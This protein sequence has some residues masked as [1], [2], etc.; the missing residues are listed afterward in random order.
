MVFDK[1]YQILKRVWT[2]SSQGSLR[3]K[4]MRVGT[5]LF[6]LWAARWQRAEETAARSVG[7]NL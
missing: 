4:F 7:S 2:V 5:V 1:P 6:F 3:I